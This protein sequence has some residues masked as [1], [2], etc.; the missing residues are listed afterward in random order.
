MPG[1]RE[2]VYLLLSV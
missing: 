2:K 1:V